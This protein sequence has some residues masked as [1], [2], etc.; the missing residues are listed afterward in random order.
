MPRF[1]HL[2]GDTAY[3][4]YSARR[5][6]RAKRRRRVLLLLSLG[7]LALAF[8]CAL[9]LRQHTGGGQPE[10]PPTARPAAA[11]T[12]APILR[13]TVTVRPAT[14]D[15]LAATPETATAPTP[16][17]TA[18]PAAKQNAMLPR[19]RA[20]YAQNSDLVGWLRMEDIDLP[21]V[22]TGGNEYYLRRGFDG[23]YATG[24]TLFLDSRCSLEKPSANWLVYGHNMAYGSMFGALTAY[25]EEEFFRLHP[26]FTFDTLYEEGRWKIAAVVRTRLGEDEL[27]YYTFFDAAGREEWQQRVDAI[28]A[29]SLYD[30]GVVPEYGDQL[31]T[32]STCG[33]TRPGTKER[34]AILAIRM[35]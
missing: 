7:L 9:A 5:G 12:A 14:V 3:Y 4:P 10:P 22:Q 33:T 27:P 19:Y 30:T 21:V 1:E 23:H 2:K 28:M 17:P 15:A 20:L 18:L 11:S 6:M 8:A 32:L 26:T 29:L 13:N 35:E 34:L 31:L 24:G 25:E 16:Q